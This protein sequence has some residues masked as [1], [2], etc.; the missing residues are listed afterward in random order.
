MSYNSNHLGAVA[1]HSGDV[2]EDL[3]NNFSVGPSA[4]TTSLHH[5]LKKYTRSTPLVFVSS[6]VVLLAI[7]LAAVSS[8]SLLPDS[9]CKA[10]INVDKD[11]CTCTCWDGRYKGPY[12][13]EGY[14]HIYWNY[15][16]P[17]FFLFSMTITYIFLAQRGIETALHALIHGT[18]WRWA[19]VI[20]AL[21]GLYPNIYS[22]FNHWN[23][24]NERYFVLTAH[25]TFFTLSELFV[26]MGFVFLLDKSKSLRDWIL[27]MIVTVA[28]THILVS[29]LD[30]GIAHIIFREG[31]I[32]FLPRDIALLLS[33]V[34]SLVS[35]SVMLVFSFQQ[36]KQRFQ[37]SN[38][39]E[40]NPVGLFKK[41][42]II[43]VVSSLCM[44]LFLRVVTF[45]Y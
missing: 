11:T 28:T 39:F 22:F 15:E 10:C 44:T 30:Q 23:F 3:P 33:D 21:A 26:T 34:I 40:P 36:Q 43:S 27:W 42:A 5:F 37:Q 19:A 16:W 14:R 29:S 12:S 31:S 13:R 25:Q 20:G 24:I 38:K 8:I 1:S 45:A 9:M 2:E 6:V 7:V 35:A 32:F 18:G 41:R 17:T 4:P